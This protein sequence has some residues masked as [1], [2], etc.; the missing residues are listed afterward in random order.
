MNQDQG[1]QFFPSADLFPSETLFPLDT[2]AGGYYVHIN[3]ILP[4]P[5]GGLS[6]NR[7]GIC[8]LALSYLSSS[9]VDLNTLDFKY[10]SDTGLVT[11]HHG[12]GDKILNLL[13][14]TGSGSRLVQALETTKCF[15][16][17][18]FTLSEASSQEF[19]QLFDQIAFE[20]IY[21]PNLIVDNVHIESYART[22]VI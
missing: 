5:N 7:M 4:L 10:N 19:Q 15:L 11:L 14:S 6:Q 9:S 20:I 3:A 1:T 18:R 22:N 17:G 8:S 2:A 16:P 12:N 21:S 13:S